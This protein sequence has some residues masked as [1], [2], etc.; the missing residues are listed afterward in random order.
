MRITRK[1]KTAFLLVCS[2]ALIISGCSISRPASANSKVQTNA[3]AFDK[4]ARE[5]F[6]DYACS[7]TLTLNYTL[8]DPSSYSIESDTMTWGDVPVNP[9]DFEEHKN[10]TLN[11]LSRLNAIEGLTGDRAV[12]C[13]VVRYYLEAD[14]ESYDYIYFTSNLAPMLGIQSQFP[15][16]MAEY[17]FDD[18][19]DVKDY[20]ALLDSFDEYTARLMEFE[21]K[22]ASEGYGM[23]QAAIK[24]AIEDCNAY[25]NEV[26]ENLLIEIFPE[27]LEALDLSEEEKNNY[28]EQN[29][30]AVTNSV[31]PA[32]A[33]MIDTL[34]QQLETAPESGRVASYENGQD[35]YKYLLTASVGTDKTPE[36]LITLTES[37]LNSSITALSIIMMNNP[38]IYNAIENAQYALE[39]PEEILEH[40]KSTLTSEQFPEAP[41]VSY[42]LKNVHESLSDVLSPAMYFIPRIDDITNNQIYLN[43]G[44]KNSGNDLMPTLAHEGYPGHMYQMTYYYNTNP[45]PIRKVYECSGYSEG[46]A[47]YA[48]SLSYDYCGFDPDV[49]DFYRL[50]NLSMA[51]NLY[52]RLDLGI[53]YENWDITRA[54]EFISQYLD[55]DEA[56]IQEIYDA[57][58]FNPTNYM[59]YGIGMEEILALRENM[60]ANLGDRFDI[61][62]FHKQLLDLGPAPFPI[63]E[64]YMPDAAEPV[65]TTSENAA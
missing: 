37:N 11:Y 17:H 39:D 12:T 15:I 29:R 3:E 44:G 16:T 61:K 24:Q 43:I 18:V 23:C 53:H 36:E 31:L 56:T 65:E 5:L 54:S 64:K 40:F 10:K 63:L 59:I 49:A 28:I 13:D 52:C 25:C 62:D 60:E 32:Y 30:N 33:M 1:L 27:K 55:L 46:W 42:T 51:L 8:K 6:I 4:L 19:Q 58:L 41:E 57:I 47:S 35:Y 14:L 20:I 21:N 9:E 45:D 48:E 26:D 38:D 7:D 34:N 2:S 50:S 22:K